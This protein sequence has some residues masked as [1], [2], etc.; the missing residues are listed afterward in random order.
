MFFDAALGYIVYVLQTYTQRCL[1]ISNKA[2]GCVLIF[3]IWGLDQ[4]PADSK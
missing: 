3:N 2:V 4:P 1:V